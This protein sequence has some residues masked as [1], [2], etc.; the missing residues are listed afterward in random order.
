MQILKL[1]TLLIIFLLNACSAKI[2]D[3][4]ESVPQF[5]LFE[6]FDGETQ[7]WGMV[8]DYKG[9]QIRRFDVV[10]KGTLL[11]V[12]HLKL[13]EDFVYDDGELQ[14]RIWLIEKNQDGTY[15]GK[16]DDVIGTAIGKT[17]GNALN[18]RY[19]LRVKTKNGELDL[20]LDDWM[21]RQD[22]QHMFNVA[23]M[24]KFGLNV[25]KISLFFQK[26]TGAHSSD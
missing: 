25:G 13:E 8:Q 10:I 22:A 23:T 11:D 4:T 19:T 17:K 16:A 3:Y 6:F 18:W 14:K 24:K 15:S 5:N 12:N 21:F 7:A 2:E 26:K 20:N 1:G 9:K